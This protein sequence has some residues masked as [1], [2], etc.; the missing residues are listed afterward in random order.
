MKID[1]ERIAIVACRVCMG[2]ALIHLGVTTYM[3]PGVRTYNKYLHAVRKSISPKSKPGDVT[4][5]GLTND[6]LNLYLI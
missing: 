1:Y 6:Q 4:L 2:I 5:G 3:E